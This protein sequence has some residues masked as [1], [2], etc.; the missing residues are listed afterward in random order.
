[1]WG[2]VYKKREKLT[3]YGDNNYTTHYDK[4]CIKDRKEGKK[5]GDKDVKRDNDW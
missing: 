5:E 1:M 4:T 2:N 3:L